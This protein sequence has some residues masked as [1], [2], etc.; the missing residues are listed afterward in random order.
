M[1]HTLPGKRSIIKIFN[2]EHTYGIFGYGSS[3][4]VGL[5]NRDILIHSE[6][7]FRKFLVNFRE[8]PAKVF[9]VET[10]IF[11]ISLSTDHFKS[12]L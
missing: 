9:P 10:F 4:K 3:N 8:F 5:K 1:R 6:D 11:Q 7:N 2:V 12:F